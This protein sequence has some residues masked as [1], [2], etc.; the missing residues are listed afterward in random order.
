MMHN[1]S[2]LDK[3][4]RELGK[5]IYSQPAD[6]GHTAWAK[7]V[8]DD[9]F[10]DWDDHGIQTVL[11]IG[12]GEGFCKSLFEQYDIH[13]NGITAGAKDYAKARKHGGSKVLQADMT[14]LSTIPDESYDLVFARHVLEHSPMPLLTLMEWNRVSSKYLLLV[15]PASD[16]WGYYG[17][18]HYSVLNK[19]QLWWLLRRSG[20]D[21]LMQ[22]DMMT[23]DEIFLDYHRKEEKDYN[24]KWN[25]PPQVVEYR[26]FCK[27]GEPQTE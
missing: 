2:G 10:F 13:W 18:N 17:K 1:Y 9:V 5:D 25:G 20:W 14:F 15:A 24:K 26:Y 4:I 7:D 27:K 22:W 3:Y 19:E 6:E 16:Y 8:I 21:I 12:C 11:D 23:S